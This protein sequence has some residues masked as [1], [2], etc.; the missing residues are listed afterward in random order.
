[1]KKCVM[2][3]FF[4]ECVMSALKNGSKLNFGL[5][6]IRMLQKG[7]NTK[8][9][10]LKLKHNVFVLVC[11]LTGPVRRGEFY[12][13][14]QTN[15]STS[16]CTCFWAWTLFAGAEMRS[17]GPNFKVVH[18]PLWSRCG[19]TPNSHDSSSHKKPILIT[20]I[21]LSNQILFGTYSIH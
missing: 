19:Y 8:W 12:S 16:T 15:R 3:A 5:Y 7:T 17:N 18:G 11:P 21:W 10:E 1:M 13:R 9:R 4:M 20:S 14:A 2:S 6:V